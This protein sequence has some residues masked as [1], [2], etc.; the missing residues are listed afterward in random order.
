[1]QIFIASTAFNGGIVSNCVFA[2]DSKEKL[3]ELIKANKEYEDSKFAW[4]WFVESMKLDF[5]L[6]EGPLSM[7]EYLAAR[8]DNGH[9]LT[10]W[11]DKEGNV[12]KE[13]PDYLLATNI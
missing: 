2:T 5:V 13:E 8:K 1:M 10:A 6:D 3:I 12:M 7:E 4:Y 9:W 11:I